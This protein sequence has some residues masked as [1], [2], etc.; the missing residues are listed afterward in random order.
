MKN[1]II[2]IWNL[3]TADDEKNDKNS[4]ETAKSSPISEWIIEPDLSSHIAT[5]AIVVKKGSVFP[6]AKYPFRLS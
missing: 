6:S 3:S 1:M 5:V 4:I 2:P